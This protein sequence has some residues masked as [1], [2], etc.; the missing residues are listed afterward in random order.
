MVGNVER[1]KERKG[2]GR[3]EGIKKLMKKGVEKEVEKE[4]DR[5]RRR[6]SLH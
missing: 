1:E 4:M 5:G 2:W 6:E 3:L